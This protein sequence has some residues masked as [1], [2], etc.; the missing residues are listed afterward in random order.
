M[1]RHYPPSTRCVCLC[2]VCDDGVLTLR[3]DS[4]GLTSNAP[5]NTYVL[6]SSLTFSFLSPPPAHSTTQAKQSVSAPNSGPHGVL[7]HRHLH[8]TISYSSPRSYTCF[9]PTGYRKQYRSVHS[10]FSVGAVPD[11]YLTFIR[12]AV[13]AKVSLTPHPS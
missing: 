7:R 13:L 9:L 3:W 6:K 4:S 12:R 8:G 10:G 11:L 5:S 2:S 1:L